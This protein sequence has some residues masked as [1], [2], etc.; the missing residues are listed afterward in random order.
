MVVSWLSKFPC[1]WWEPEHDHILCILDGQSGCCFDSYSKAAFAFCTLGRSSLCHIVML[2]AAVESLLAGLSGTCRLTAGAG[3]TGSSE[4]LER[5]GNSCSIMLKNDP[6]FW[7]W[8]KMGAKPMKLPI[9][10]AMGHIRSIWRQGCP[11]NEA[12]LQPGLGWGL[13]KACAEFLLSSERE[14]SRSIHST[15]CLQHDLVPVYSFPS[16]TAYPSQGSLPS[17]FLSPFPETIRKMVGGERGR[18]KFRNNSSE[19]VFLI[20]AFCSIGDV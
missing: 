10:L 1:N 9:P 8:P 20:G 5:S 14:A 15:L 3:T 17:Y 13:G 6:V 11:W 16:D 19:A 18:W 7:W 2:R 12:S 4:Q